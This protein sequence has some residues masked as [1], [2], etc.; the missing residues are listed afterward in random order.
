MVGFYRRLRRMHDCLSENSFS[1]DNENNL[2]VLDYPSPTPV[3]ETNFLGHLFYGLNSGHV[4]SV[5]ARGKLIMANKKILTVD[6]EEILAQACA[7]VFPLPVN[8]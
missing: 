3:D 7:A 4:D 8:Q 2:V 1:G 5:I 6:E